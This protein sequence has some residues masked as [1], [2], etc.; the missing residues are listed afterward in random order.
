MTDDFSKAKLLDFLAYLGKKGL[1][2]R[3]TVAARKAAANT[4]LSILSDQEAQDLSK[5]DLDQIAL[6]FSN[7]KGSEFKPESIKIYKSRVSS[8]LEDLKSYKTN[9]LAFKPNITAQ[10]AP[11]GSKTENAKAPLPKG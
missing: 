4:F 9:P 6:R 10:R 5:I 2:N 8:A 11:A 3:A 1:M 7:L